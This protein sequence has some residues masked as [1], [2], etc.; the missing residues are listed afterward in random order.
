[1]HL[2]PA[3]ALIL[4]HSFVAVKCCAANP[5]SVFGRSYSSSVPRDFTFKAMNAAHRIAL[6]LTGNRVAASVSGMP[7]LELTTIGRRSGKP[8]PVMLTSPAQLGETYV[9]VASRGGDD[10][11]PAWLLNLTAN[12]AVQVRVVGRQP[13]PM[14]ARVA[15]A[16]ERASLWPLIT[17]KYSNYA[18]YQ[19]RTDRVIPLVLLEPVD[20]D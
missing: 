12:P 3:V 6:K 18:G 19:R 5:T 20:S 8:H 7:V 13:T 14:R 17:A 2:S 16:E 4:Y 10:I 9:V 1:V 11:S 15:D